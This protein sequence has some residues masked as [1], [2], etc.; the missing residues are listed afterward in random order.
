M[1]IMDYTS[2]KGEYLPDYTKNSTWE[3]LCAYMDAHSQK[4]IY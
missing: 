2:I 1:I 3:L 4:L